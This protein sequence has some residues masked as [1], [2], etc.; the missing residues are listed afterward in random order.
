M[1]GSNIQIKFSND[2]LIHFKLVNEGFD[3][4]CFLFCVYGF[5][6][7]LDKH[8]LWDNLCDVLQGMFNLWLI[9]GDFNVLLHDKDK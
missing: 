4:P 6:Y 3:Q 8:V 5:S 2:R 1:H 7:H 9:L